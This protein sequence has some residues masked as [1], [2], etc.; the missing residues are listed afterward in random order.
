[1]LSME[2]KF[3][4]QRD[5]QEWQPYLTLRGVLTWPSCMQGWWTSYQA[6]P[7]QFSLDLLKRLMSQVGTFLLKWMNYHCSF[8]PGTFKMKKRDLQLEGF[9][10]FIMREE[11]VYIVDNVS[12]TYV[13]ITQEIYNNIVNGNMRF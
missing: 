10:P 2:W 13:L 11:D 1:M 4:G 8:F 12:K 5:E 9:N 7:G 6:M 3:L